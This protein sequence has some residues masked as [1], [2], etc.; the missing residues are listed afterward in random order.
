VPTD[1]EWNTADSFGAWNNNTHTYNSALKLPSAGHRYRINGWFSGQG[2][3]G[4]YW[5]STVD[6]TD[7]RYLR[8]HSPAASTS[9]DYRAYGNTVR[10]LK[11]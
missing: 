2:T 1:T 4:S 8:F 9:S 6:G 11:N 10:C 5:S 7:A 3:S